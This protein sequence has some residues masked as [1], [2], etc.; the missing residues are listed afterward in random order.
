MKSGSLV[1]PDTKSLEDLNDKEEIAGNDEEISSNISEN[2]APH[3]DNLISDSGK[4]EEDFAA[5]QSERSQDSSQIQQNQ[6]NLKKKLESVLTDNGQKYQNDSA[7]PLTSSELESQIEN[8]TGCDYS[9]KLVKKIVD[10]DDVSRLEKFIKKEEVIDNYEEEEEEN[11]T[12]ADL[13][14]VE[15]LYVEMNFKGEGVVLVPMIQYCV[16]KGALKCFKYLLLNGLGGPERVMVDRYDR[17][18]RYKWDCLATAIYFGNEEIIEIL[19]A[20][21]IEPDSNPVYLEA[22]ILSHRNNIAKEIV[23]HLREKKCSKYARN[24]E[25]RANCRSTG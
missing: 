13:P 10:H 21:G 20:K 14:P 9:S 23:A 22:A 6:P 25:C 7:K 4:I 17:P 19:K 2:N 3:R 1:E 11:V 15:V 24:T 12:F 16:M 18:T 5:E 8:A